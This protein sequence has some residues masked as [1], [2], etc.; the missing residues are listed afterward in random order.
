MIIS[1]TPVRI[2]LGGGGTDLAEFYQKQRGFLVSAAV[3]KF[4]LI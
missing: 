3:N 4:V 2:P 1:Q